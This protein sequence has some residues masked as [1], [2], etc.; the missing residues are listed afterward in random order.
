MRMI[1]TI[2]RLAFIYLRSKLYRLYPNPKGSW[3]ISQLQSWL[4]SV[5]APLLLASVSN[6]WHDDGDSRKEGLVGGRRSF[7][8]TS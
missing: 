1:R 2:L 6:T 4:F 7:I 5:A 8:F 3:Q